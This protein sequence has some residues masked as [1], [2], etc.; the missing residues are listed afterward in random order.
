MTKQIHESFNG[1]SNIESCPLPQAIEHLE[2]LREAYPEQNKEIAA[3]ITSAK[4]LYD[5][6][7]DTFR[8]DGEK[9]MIGQISNFINPKL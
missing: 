6:G 3:E 8:F 9:Q 2:T 5:D 7:F 1:L 4:I